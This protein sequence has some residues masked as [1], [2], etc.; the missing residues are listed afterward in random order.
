[1]GRRVPWHEGRTSD[2]A[3]AVVLE[4][5]RAMGQ[6]Y[7]G[8]LPDWLKI[9]TIHASYASLPLMCGRREK[10]TQEQM[11]CSCPVHGTL[12]GSYPSDERKVS[13]LFLIP[14]WWEPFCS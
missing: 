11:L 12:S 14:L 5:N 10:S 9:S 2:Q 7:H 6:G 1:M 3:F 4:I 13:V 8:P